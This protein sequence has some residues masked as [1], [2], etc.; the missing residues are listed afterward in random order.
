MV[1]WIKNQDWLASNQLEFTEEDLHGRECYVGL[2]LS[3]TTDLTTYVLAFPNQEGGYELITRTF[4]PRD[5]AVKRSK[6][7]KV[8]Y[9]QWEK[10][11]WMTFTSGNIIDYEEIYNH[12]MADVGKFNIRE[13][14]F[15]RWNATAL[16]TKLTEEGVEC[17]GF[18]QGYKSMSPAVKSVEALVLQKKLNHGNNPVLSWCVA[19]V[20]IEVDAAENM[21]IDKSK[22]VERVDCAVALAMA[23]GRAE[24][25]R[26][27]EVDWTSLIG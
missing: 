9:M 21:K 11:G 22:A 5:N 26:E 23:V 6:E 24:S 15:D 18:G 3:S 13:L 19:N 2:D 17:V 20:A 25:F 27:A 7:D 4:M 16:I 12:L 1:T 10:E 8:S 14:S